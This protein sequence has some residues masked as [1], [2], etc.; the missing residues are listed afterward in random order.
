MTRQ[1]CALPF[2]VPLMADSTSKVVVTR[3][4]RQHLVQ[5]V[6]GLGLAP[7]AGV[8]ELIA[9]MT[10]QSGQGFVAA[11]HRAVIGGTEDAEDAFPMEEVATRR[12]LG[13]LLALVFAVAHATGE[14]WLI[15][16][17]DDDSFTEVTTEKANLGIALGASL[18]ASNA[19]LFHAFTVVPVS[20]AVTCSNFDIGVYAIAQTTIEVFFQRSES[21]FLTKFTRDF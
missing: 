10:F 19:A 3:H 15:I 20:T 6:A 14:D 12:G 7:R 9:E 8:A 17:I 2:G 1:L 5:R 11:D 21:N 13:S 18:V 16:H 4:L